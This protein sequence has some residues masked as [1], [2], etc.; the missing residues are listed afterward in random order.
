[1][2]QLLCR[3]TA[4]PYAGLQILEAARLYKSVVSAL[5]E[6]DH[7]GQSVDM[8]EEALRMHGFQS[9]SE[10]LAL[11]EDY[12]PFFHL[13]TLDFKPIDL[14]EW[15]IRRMLRGERL[16]N[17][18]VWVETQERTWLASYCGSPVLDDSGRIIAGV[19]S[20]RDITPQK[21]VENRIRELAD[22]MTQLAWTAQPNG[23]VNWYNRRWFEYTGTT[24]E[25]MLGWGWQS[26]QDP[27]IL[28][29]VM[30]RWT[31]SIADGTAF[32]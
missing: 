23:D 6:G 26:V 31:T 11:A 30:K 19:L 20:I 27:K 29:E 10:M 12:A 14:H 1:M 16:R 25:Q 5:T 28:P 4:G 13:K 21:D 18:E 22:S 9:R 24:H 2:R 7:S 17:F 8:N 15:P 32:D 3:D